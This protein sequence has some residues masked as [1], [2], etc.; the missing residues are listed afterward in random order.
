[1]SDRKS[2]P[3]SRAIW[4]LQHICPGGSDALLGDLI[5]RFREGQS[6]GWFWKQVLITFA[7]GVLDEIRR[8]WPHFCYAIAGTITMFPFLYKAVNG[9]PFALHWWVLPWPWS[10]IVLE[11]SATAV[12]ALAALPILGVTL[13]INGAFRWINL[14][15]TG[16]LNL[17]LITF[18]HYLR[19]YFGP[20]LSRPVPGE[21]Y[22][23]TLIIPGTLQI[24]LF[25]S[26]FLVAAW[27]GCVSP[28]QATQFE[29]QARL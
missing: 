7:V 16:A 14:F 15:R 9:L 26:T 4:F 20:W 25:F 27:L 24:L 10:Q 19:V 11:Q 28:R 23:R 12:F 1:M 18:G 17:A 3:P 5:E 21:P 13:A 22:H 6:R 2:D 8:H 29:R